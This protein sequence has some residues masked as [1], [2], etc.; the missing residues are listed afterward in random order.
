MAHDNGIIS[1]TGSGV[2]L[3]GDIQTVLGESA[4]SLGNL[5]KS[6]H[7]NMWSRI[8]PIKYA[9]WTTNNGGATD[10]DG[11]P[12]GIE[13]P[14]S[15]SVL[16]CA[17]YLLTHVKPTGGSSSPYRAL[18]FNGYNHNCY[19]PWN[20]LM[21]SGELVKKST[22]AA[23]CVKFQRLSNLPTGNIQISDLYP[24][25]YFCVCVNG[26]YKTLAN[27]E[28]TLTFAG[29]NCPG[30]D[31]ANIGSTITIKC[32]MA[33]AQITE[34]T[35]Q[36]EKTFYSL[37]YDGHVAVSTVTLVAPLENVPSF[38]ILGLATADTRNLRLN[39]TTTNNNGTFYNAATQT[40]RL[41]ADYT[42]QS[43]VATAKLHSAGT[44][45]ETQTISTSSVSPD[46]IERGDGGYP[47]TVGFSA[48]YP[49]SQLSLPDAPA[50]DYYD[51]IITL[52]YSS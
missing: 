3:L 31:N 33:S 36:P 25:K 10:S 17:E 35:A 32:G 38:V 12:Y 51:L 39:S 23:A 21:P 22:N 15:G 20:I 18:D 37:S 2:S 1:T 40:A 13:V 19:C 24:G 47:Y 34:W 29:T 7:I 8:K 44:V 16:D 46:I 9:S 50:G 14:S 28:S 43:A 30:F 26:Y 6:S 4:N 42:L 5:C 27:D 45:V 49:I 11:N 41:S 48:P 52:T